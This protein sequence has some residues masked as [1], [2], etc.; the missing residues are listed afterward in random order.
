MLQ[1]QFLVIYNPAKCN[2]NKSKETFNL[3][4]D[5]VRSAF[6]SYFIKNGMS[7]NARMLEEEM[8]QNI[9]DKKIKPSAADNYA[10]SAFFA[11]AEVKYHI[12]S[13]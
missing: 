6:G 8:I 9:R 4:D 11:A 10:L 2:L 12:V 3:G 1:I 13:F 5:Q 7:G